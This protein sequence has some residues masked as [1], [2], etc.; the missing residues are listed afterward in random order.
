[1]HLITIAAHNLIPG[2]VQPLRAA[3]SRFFK[4]RLAWLE[5]DDHVLGI[6]QYE[7]VDDYTDL[8]ELRLHVAE[9]VLRAHGAPCSGT[10]MA[11]ALVGPRTTFMEAALALGLDVRRL[12][13]VDQLGALA[14]ST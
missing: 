10:V 5:R 12:S 14:D 3:L 2:R 4:G 6:G 11:Y 9:V 13:A 8:E 1:M 7:G